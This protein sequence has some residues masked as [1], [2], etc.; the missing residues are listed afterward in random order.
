MGLV[1][2]ESEMNRR[3]QESS[4]GAASYGRA[5]ASPLRGSSEILPKK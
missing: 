4:L 3:H 5:R 1:Y 2:K